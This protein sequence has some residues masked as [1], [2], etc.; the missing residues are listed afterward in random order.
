[1]HV[2]PER[3]HVY[4]LSSL[5]KAGDP[6]TTVH[7]VLRGGFPSQRSWLLDAPLTQGMTG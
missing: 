6:V 2:A 5:A 7:D 4:R 3:P 1:M